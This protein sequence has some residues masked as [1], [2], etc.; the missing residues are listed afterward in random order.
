MSAPTVSATPATSLRPAKK[1]SYTWVWWV[2][3]AIIVVAIIVWIIVA[4]RK[5]VV[6]TPAPKPAPVTPTRVI[7]PRQ[8]TTLT[9]FGY[10]N[11][12]R[13]WYDFQGQGVK[14]DYGRF[15]GNAPNIWFSVALAGS[16]NQ[17]TPNDPTHVYNST[18]PHDP[19]VPA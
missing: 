15:V 9:D 18:A 16:T 2:L 7:L 5:P 14:N 11:Q 6:P 12:A 4:N 10:A 1:K 3:V 8:T 17:Y 19:Y 13:G